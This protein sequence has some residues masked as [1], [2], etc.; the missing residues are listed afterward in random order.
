MRNALRK[1]SYSLNFGLDKIIP[2]S[3]IFAI[4]LTFIVFIMGITIAGQSPFDMTVFWAKGFW[5]FLL[6]SMQMVLVLV[7][8]FTLATTPAG[9]KG[10][11]AIA[12]IP[13]SGVSATIFIMIVSSAL[14][15]ISWGL[16]LVGSA[17]LAR[18]LARNLK[19]ADFK[20]L[21]AAGYTGAMVGTMGLSFSE[22]LLVNT[23]GHFLEKEIGLIPY[24]D[25]VFSP[26][27]LISVL[28][29]TFVLLPLFYWLIHPEEKDTPEIPAEIKNRFEEQSR[30]AVE[31]A[32]IAEGKPTIAERMDNSPIINV[33][34]S[35]MGFV[36]IVY[37]FVTQGFNLTLDIFNFTLLFLGILLHWTP[38]RLLNAFEEGVKASYGIVLQFPFYAGIQGMMGS[39]GL[40]AIM[41]GWF[42]AISTTTT[43][44]M[45]TYISAAF[46]NL[47]IPSSGGIFMIQGPVMVKAGAALG[48]P[49]AKIVTAFS[50]G[51]VISNIIQPFWAIPLLGIA[52]LKMRD[53]M[54]FC[55]LGFTI[56]S[57]VFITLLTVL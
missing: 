53:I 23:P 34:I 1:F 57:V 11:A 24:S 43:F 16:G 36:Y 6:F 19:K 2:D 15:Y 55:V 46:V 20:L 40:V 33:T 51:E 13:K 27:V 56:A 21:V 31:S 52:G 28:L 17:V 25:T 44:P 7:T 49:A 26:G 37:W 35:I 4:L 30:I 45:W 5:G 14:A 48:V 29:L 3:F 8:G 9:Q 54:G 39:S 47:F 42:T 22:A 41:A 10:L 50:S 32:A 18:E 38:R 12:R